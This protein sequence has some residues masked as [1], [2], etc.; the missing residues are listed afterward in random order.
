MARASAVGLVQRWMPGDS[1]AY[2]TV[3]ISARL[4][5]G[6]YKLGIALVDPATGK[7]GVDFAM[8]DRQVDGRYL[9]GNLDVREMTAAERV[10]EPDGLGAD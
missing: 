10:R 3:P 6:V 1:G 8:E 5:P 4:T 7:P 9:V 2:V